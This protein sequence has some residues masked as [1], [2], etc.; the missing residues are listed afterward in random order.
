MLEI[1]SPAGSPEGVIAA[2]QNGA[3]AVYVG[4][5]DFNA[6][7]NAKNFT[8]E[9]FR[10]AAEYCR[11][12]GV[13]VYVTLNT[14]VSDRELPAVAEQAKVA[15]RYGADAFI[16]QDLGVMRAL[17]QAVPEVPIHASTQ[18]TVHNLEGVKL[19]AAMGFSRV[20]LARELSRSEIAYICKYAPI[21]TEV[22]AHGAL[23]MSYSGQC[24]MS[25]VIGRRSGNRGLCAQPC[26]LNYAASGHDAEYLLSLKDNCLIEFVEEIERL[27]V[28]CVKIE[29][30]MRR[31]EYAAVVTGIYSRAIKDKKS[32]SLDDMRALKSA[33]SRQGFTTGYYL[34]QKGPDMFGVREE[35][36]K[37][38]Q[39]IFATARKNYLNGEFQRIPVRFAGMIRRGEPAKMAAVDDKGNNAVTQGPTPEPAFH[40]EITSTM[41]QT[42]LHKTGG[43]PFCCIGVKSEVESGLSLP[44]SAI[45]EMRRDLLAELLE[46]RKDLPPRREGEFSPGYRL[47]NREDK[48]IMTVSVMKIS[49][50][51]KELAAMKPRILYIP[52][53]ELKKDRTGL[54][55]FLEDSDISIVARLPRIIFDSEKKEVTA[56]LE[57]AR[58]LGVKEALIGNVGHL[59]Y[60]KGLGFEARGDFGLNI[61]N[62]QSLRVMKDLGLLSATLSFELRMEQIADM[63]KCIDTELII[64]G[65]LPLMLTENCIIKNSTGVCTC[66]NFSGLLDRQG[67]SFPVVQEY[68]CRNV[69]LNSKKLFLAD[70]RAATSSAGLWAER[71]MFTTENAHECAAVMKRYL[72]Q[73]D[74]E[75]GTFTR[76]LYFRGVE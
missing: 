39:V 3:D 9:E 62:S 53:E 64:Y 35:E 50:L 19:A 73:G 72:G 21:E 32:P 24:Y 51:S 71:L 17:K 47:L 55:P 30:R 74:Y 63:S 34:D 58:E 11:A 25:A 49:Q 70:K 56:L 36:S 68:K 59:Q 42:Q 2:V 29:G 43:T 7:K 20:V 13:K 44:T 57:S 69:V 41:L 45:N 46:K 37:S 10:K 31:A 61:Y 8:A 65:R 75:P 6:R 26:R 12:R 76:G 33:F 28:A 23:C 1:L 22:F 54:E 27:G 16:V 52:V 14:L 48:P 15:C 40:K 5:G 18:M 66:D 60:V 4:F 38:D 67:A